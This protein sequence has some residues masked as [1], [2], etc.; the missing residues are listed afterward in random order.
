MAISSS[1]NGSQPSSFSN[2]VSSMAD[3]NTT[4]G[5]RIAA[6]LIN[7]VEKLQSVKTALTAAKQAQLAASQQAAMFG[8]Q[9]SMFKSIYPGVQII[10]GPGA[11][12][13]AGQVVGNAGRQLA[14]TGSSVLK[15][16]GGMLKANFAISAA[17]AIFTNLIDLLSHRETGKQFLV[18]S[19]I[20]TA[21]YTGIGASATMIG[22]M[23]GSIFPGVGTLIGIGVGALVAFLASKLY[24]DKIRPQATTLALNA[25][26]NAMS[27]S[28]SAS[29]L[30]ASG[31]ANPSAVPLPVPAS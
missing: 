1:V 4:Q 26:D 6:P 16:V 9:A 29:S 27:S 3:S 19:A 21:A 13:S 2:L 31:A 5:M 15:T 25:V 17:M 22:G 20:D 12:P 14:T 28:A 23:V 8:E 30:P 10:G 24:E 7:T 11:F 18:D